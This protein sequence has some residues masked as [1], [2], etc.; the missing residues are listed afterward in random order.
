[1]TTV[2]ELYNFICENTLEVVARNWYN[3]IERA[4][5]AGAEVQRL[6]EIN[7][8]QSE[9][10]DSMIIVNCQALACSAP[11][12]AEVERLRVMV[13]MLNNHLLTV[14]QFN[15]FSMQVGAGGIMP[16]SV[17]AGIV[18]AIA[19]SE[20]DANSVRDAT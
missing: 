4:L 19:A 18:E 2:D 3:D 13:A 17:I 9:K 11:V 7:T 15:S 8:I 14:W 1:M 10:L 20:A 5:E 12:A 16:S 6:R